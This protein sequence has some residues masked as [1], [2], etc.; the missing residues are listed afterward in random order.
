MLE[1]LFA[2]IDPSRPHDVGFAESWHAR[3][4]TLAWGVLAPTSVLVARFFKIMPGQDW[5][6]ELDNRFWWRFHW[7]G[8]TAVLLLTFAA[9]ALIYTSRSAHLTL[10]GQLGYAVIGCLLLQVLLGVFRGSK[11]GPTDRRTDGSPRG[12]HYDMTA[13]RL[14]FEH[15]HKA[16]G[17][18]T[19]LLAAVTIVAGLWLSNA[20]VWMWIVIFGWWIVLIAAFAVLQSRGRAI[21]TYAA[22][23]G[24]DPQHP[25]N[26]RA[27]PGWGMR[28]PHEHQPGE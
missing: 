10:H 23:W 18:C 27:V 9:F 7:M 19:L 2:S 24:T 6:R 8:Q 28:R 25:G 14:T 4:M 5:P 16:V 17:Y 11:G 13:W 21:D 26:R 12:D 15:A 22:I 1:W 20:P 3:L